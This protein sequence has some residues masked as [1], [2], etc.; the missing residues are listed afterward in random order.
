MRF[1]WPDRERRQALSP[2]LGYSVREM[3]TSLSRPKH[4]PN[5]R[6][7]KACAFLPFAETGED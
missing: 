2:S 4:L 7:G 3:L 6:D 5:F 1:L